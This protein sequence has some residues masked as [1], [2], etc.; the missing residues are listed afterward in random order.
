MNIAVCLF[1]RKKR[2]LNDFERFTRLWTSEGS[3]T[4]ISETTDLLVFSLTTIS[5]VFTQWQLS[6]KTSSGKL[7]NGRK[8]LG[9]GLRQLTQ[10]VYKNKKNYL[11][12]IAAQ[13]N[14]GSQHIHVLYKANFILQPAGNNM[15]FFGFSAKSKKAVSEAKE[16]RYWILDE[17]N[18]AFWSTSQNFFPTK[19]M[20]YSVSNTSS[21]K[22][23][24]RHVTT[25]LASGG[26][27][28]VGGEFSRYTFGPLVSLAI[29]INAIVYLYILADKVHLFMSIMFPDR[30]WPFPAG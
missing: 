1:I 22:Q 10:I 27:I 16:R 28:K 19:L 25:C 26:R 17:Q 24:I 8:F 9:K 20:A 12:Q 5:R 3:V 23:R 18:N 7:N 4:A 2:D 14:S 13:Y 21:T 30:S 15:S 6:Q 29:A 11:E